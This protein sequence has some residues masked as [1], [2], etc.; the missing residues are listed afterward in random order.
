M[1]NINELGNWL[2]IHNPRNQRREFLGKMRE[3]FLYI[4]ESLLEVLE[5]IRLL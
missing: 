3:I 2:K 4:K 1:D 5:T